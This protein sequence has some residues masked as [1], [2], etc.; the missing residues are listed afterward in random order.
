MGTREQFILLIWCC[1][2]DTAHLFYPCS[3]KEK[4]ITNICICQRA[5][6]WYGE[7]RK[8]TQVSYRSRIILELITLC[9][10]I[11][12]SFFFLQRSQTFSVLFQGPPYFPEPFYFQLFTDICSCFYTV[13]LNRRYNLS[14][15]M[16]WEDE[17]ELPE[18]NIQAGSSS[19][20]YNF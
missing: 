17:E 5:S 1:V 16:C 13:S 15:N 6:I 7:M 10:C 12:V 8:R 19:R 2:S 11:F 14:S 3:E 20:S 9:F 18:Q 4:D